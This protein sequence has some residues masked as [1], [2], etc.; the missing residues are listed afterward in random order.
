MRPVFRIRLKSTSIDFTT[1]YF[2]TAAG[3]NLPR[4]FVDIG[5]YGKFPSLNKKI[6]P[7][8]DGLMWIRGMDQRP[9]LLRSDEFNAFLAKQSFRSAS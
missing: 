6:N 1:V 9:K 8:P 5:L 2:F 4:I 7:L 3:L